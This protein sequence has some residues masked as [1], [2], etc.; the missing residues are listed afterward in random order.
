MGSA[1]KVVC[2]EQAKEACAN[3]AQADEKL[4]SVGRW[5]S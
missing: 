1:G 5:P 4:L 2:G 3:D